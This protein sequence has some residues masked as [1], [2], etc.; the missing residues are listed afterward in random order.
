MRSTSLWVLLAGLAAL[1]ATRPEVRAE[2]LAPGVTYSFYQAPGPNRVYVVAVDRFRAEY[3]LKIGWPQKKRNFTSRQT[4]STIV[5]H[6]DQ[7]PAHDVIAAVNASFFGTTPAITGATASDGEML[8]QPTG[9]YETFLF[10]D[11]RLPV[12]V[13][14]ISHLNGTVTF[15]DGSTTTLHAYNKARTADT[16]VA[17]TPQWAST[18][19]TAGQGVEIILS[20]VT[21]PMRGDKTVS[22]IVTAIRSGSA[23]I[24][25]AIP[26]GG[27][28]LS[29]IG[30]PV[31]TL[32]AKVSV[33]DRLAMFF[34]TSN[35]NYN[36]ANMAVTGAGWLLK[37][38]AAN[39][40]NWSKH[41]FATQRHPRT[42]L[43]WNS[44]HLFLMVCD[45]RCNG[46]VGMTFQELADFLTGTL[47]ATDAINLDGGGSSTMW[48]NG[49]VRN[50]PADSCG[51]QRAV[52]NAVLLVRED[53]ATQFPFAAPFAPTGRLPGW[54]DKFNYNPVKTFSP[55]APSGDGYVLEVKPAS[56]LDSVRRGDFGDTDYAVEADIYCE[57]RPDLASNGYERYSLFARDSGTGALG[58]T[59]APGPGNCYAITYDSDDGRLR[60]ARYLNGSLTD[61]RDSNR[62]YLTS[63]AWRRFRIECVGSRIRYLVDGSLIA[64]VTDANHPRGYFGIGYQESFSSNSNIHGTR[65]DNFRALRLAAPDKAT[66]P[67][68]A[69][70][71]RGVTSTVLSW[72]AGAEATSH[73][74]YFGTVSPGVFQG[75]QTATTFNI[76][77]LELGAT[78]YWRID[79]VNA[80]GTTTGDVWSFTAQ[81]YMGDWDNDGD[82]DQDDFGRFQACLSGFAAQTDPACERAR[83][84]P[85]G[86][87]DADVD[88]DD[89]A[90][91]RNCMTGPQVS[92]PETCLE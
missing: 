57:Y 80:Y 3:K 54:D 35:A 65:A 6:Y 18:T 12:I 34:D 53:T 56:G 85:V 48:A 21:Y 75:N 51:T 22:G 47:G 68:P 11:T 4:V 16:L 2:E 90:L 29:A 26:A 64:D 61:F 25:N 45:G 84:H 43:A 87:P 36:N 76:G 37:N 62:I 30:A 33:G 10:G 39:T 72:T 7:P 17:Y 59:S 14:N 41:G 74:V 70:L 40:A 1:F 60:A 79:E 15:A 92:P 81:R 71:A 44:T 13:E 28:V 27:M 69:D 52:A 63:T 83:I 67:S 66:N 78:Y 46:I 82:V 58:S 23:S 9:S 24:N 88:S 5:S 31:A 89:L 20:D 8:E 42:V 77:P 19:G 50:V 73:N 55:A 32:T 91:F 86:N 38:G 49:T